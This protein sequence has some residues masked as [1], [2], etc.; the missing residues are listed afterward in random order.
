MS[1]M[2]S[3][4]VRMKSSGF[5]ID[6]GGLPQ[7]RVILGADS[8]GE[9]VAFICTC[10]NEENTAC[11]MEQAITYSRTLI[12]ALKYVYGA[13]D[14][15]VF[16]TGV[17]KVASSAN[18]YELNVLWFSF[19]YHDTTIQTAEYMAGYRKCPRNSEMTG[20]TDTFR[21]SHGVFKF[22]CLFC[23]MNTYY[24]EVSTPVQVV[25]K[26]ITMFVSSVTQ[27]PFMDDIQKRKNIRTYFAATNP[28]PTADFRSQ[29]NQESVLD[30]GTVVTMK[31]GSPDTVSNR[32]DPSPAFG[33]R[34]GRIECEGLPVTFTRSTT[35]VPSVT[36]TIGAVHAGKMIL[37]YIEDV[38][39]C[40]NNNFPATVFD[41]NWQ[42]WPVRI[43]ARA[44]SILQECTK[45]PTGKFSGSYG[46]GN[47]SICEQISNLRT[48]V[49]T[50]ILNP[51]PGN[52][53]SV[54]V[55]QKKPFLAYIV[56]D[57]IFL[58]LLEIRKFTP[59]VPI[60]THGFA[61]QTLLDTNNMTFVNAN[62]K[63][64]AVE[65]FKIYD[66]RRNDMDAKLIETKLIAGDRELILFSTQGAY[67]DPSVL[68][69]LWN[70]LSP[71]NIIDS[72]WQTWA[73][74]GG[75]VFCVILAIVMCCVCKKKPNNNIRYQ[76]QS[77]GYY[78][79][80]PGVLVQPHQFHPPEMRYDLRNDARYE[81]H[82]STQM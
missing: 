21:D 62:K 28:M 1:M 6:V 79:A 57:G 9:Q 34:V 56:V 41:P 75:V 37:V 10:T 44:P 66:S 76:Q 60:G 65:I 32:F 2:G 77:A 42:V 59:L 7:K 13:P 51:T 58:N 64:I 49:L 72:S 11:T 14:E 82:P 29:Y 8:T 68:Q 67:K 38:E 24:N 15:M 47:I 26:L 16:I 4:S 69:E 48:T 55:P 25:Y 53:R 17:T 20:G 61:L 80:G 30:I 19:D 73:I 39:C 70:L 18:A 63:Q 46:G 50:P 36:F 33:A 31:M 5:R 40:N 74:M 78:A 27:S 35:G 45:C 12:V 3:A 52:R 23:P 22:P 71:S 43:F 81:E 54:V